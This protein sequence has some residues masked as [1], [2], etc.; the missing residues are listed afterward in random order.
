[1]DTPDPRTPRWRRLIE[2]VHADVAAGRLRPGDE[3]PTTGQL[4]VMYHCSSS[5]VRRALRHLV[6]D[7]VVV[8]R[9]GWGRFITTAT[10]TGE[11]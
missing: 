8:G 2:D 11:E 3:L 4:C 9:P 10:Q 7:G 6:N 5:T 1:V